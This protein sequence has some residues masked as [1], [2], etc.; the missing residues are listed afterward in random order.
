MVANDH[1]LKE[2]QLSSALLPSLHSGSIEIGSA[3]IRSKYIQHF[4]EYIQT[5]GVLVNID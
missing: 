3:G 5:T 2:N 4:Y 1:N